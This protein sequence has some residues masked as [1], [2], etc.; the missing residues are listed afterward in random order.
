[1]YNILV[2]RV[3]EERRARTTQKIFEETKA[4]N[5]N[6]VKDI[7]FQIQEAQSSHK[8]KIIPRQIMSD[9]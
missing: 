4:E 3:T 2:T 1:M 6:L 5:S 9:S 7:N 8:G